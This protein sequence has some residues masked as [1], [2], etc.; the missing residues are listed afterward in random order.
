MD[1]INTSELNDPNHVVTSVYYTMAT[2]CWKN[3]TTKTAEG[4]MD[5]ANNMMDAYLN[6]YVGTPENP[7]VHFGRV[8]IITTSMLL[9]YIAGDPHPMDKPHGTFNMSSMVV[10]AHSG[11]PVDRPLEEFLLT[12]VS[13]A[14]NWQWEELENQMGEHIGTDYDLLDFIQSLVNMFVGLEGPQRLGWV[15]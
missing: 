9:R 2:E 15:T 5:E 7:L 12:V 8:G 1:D 11:M 4:D 6:Q 10:D 13:M 3:V 14:A